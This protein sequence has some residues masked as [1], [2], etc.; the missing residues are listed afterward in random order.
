MKLFTVGYEGLDIDDFIAGLKKA[1]IQRIADVRK[2]PVSRKKGFSKNKLAE[3]LAREGLAYN[4]FPALG[5][6]TEW[7]KQA[8]AEVITRKKMF[9]D[10]A[11][12][13]LPRA[14]AELTEIQHLMREKGLSLLC[15]ER[16]A[17]DC[18]R[19]YVADAIVKRAKSKVR[20][21]NVVIEPTGFF[22]PP[23][24][25]ARSAARGTSRARPARATRAPE[26]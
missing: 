4:H 19:S 2:N 25:S 20:V 13:I 15:F 9:A 26:A 23:K 12:K 3:A 6:P 8:K 22:A 10:Y 5:V 18:H 16:D 14:E 1:G 21:E 7:R 11:K 17:S 24:T